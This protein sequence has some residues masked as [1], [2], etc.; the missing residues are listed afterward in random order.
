MKLPLNCDVEYIDTFLNKE[1]SKELF[2][3]LIRDYQI[4]KARMII[5]T[6]GKIRNSRNLFY[7]I[8]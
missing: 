7:S 6:G 2:N 1:E 8:K 3:L 4:D 5:K